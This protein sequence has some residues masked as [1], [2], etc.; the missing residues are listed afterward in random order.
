MD[1]KYWLGILVVIVILI[2][3]YYYGKPGASQINAVTNSAP[4]SSASSP[5]PSPSPTPTSSYPTGL[6]EGEVVRDQVGGQ[7]FVLQNGV[8]DWYNAAGYAAVGSPPYTNVD[9]ATLWLVPNG[10]IL[11]ASG[12]ITGQYA[13]STGIYPGGLTENEVVRDSTVGYVYILQNGAKNW[14]TASGY[15]AAGSP[16]Y[17][18][19]D[20]TTLF[21]IKNGTIIG[22]NTQ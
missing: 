21:T 16:P 6:T 14:Y 11:G 2:L 5:S 1:A 8:K 13:T 12:P 9:P 18:N 22:S 15:A 19:V 3:L 4:S 7:V 10:S 20:Q 17:T